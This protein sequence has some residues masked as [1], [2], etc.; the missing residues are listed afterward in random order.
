MK[1]YGEG[2]LEFPGTHRVVWDF[3]DGPFDTCNQLLIQEAKRRGLSFNPPEATAKPFA[4]ID[5][6]PKDTPARR[7]RPRRVENVNA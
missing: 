2:T 1:I 7:G 3:S 4:V 6:K 5:S